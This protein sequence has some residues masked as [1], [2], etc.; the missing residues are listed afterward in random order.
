MTARAD[1]STR[2]DR[3]QG[4]GER[5][6]CARLRGSVLLLPLM[7]FRAN[8][9]SARRR[10]RPPCRRTRWSGNTGSPGARAQR[11]TADGQRHGRRAAEATRRC[12]GQIP[13]LSDGHRQLR[14]ST[15]ATLLLWTCGVLTHRLLGSTCLLG[16]GLFALRRGPSVLLLPTECVLPTHRELRRPLVLQLPMSRRGSVTRRRCCCRRRAALLAFAV[17]GSTACAA[18]V[19]PSSVPSDAQPAATMLGSAVDSDAV[20]ARSLDS[21]LD[22]GISTSDTGLGASAG[23]LVS[24]GGD[25]G[26]V[27][28]GT[29]DATG[30]DAVAVALDAGFDAVWP[31]ISARV[32]D[33]GLVPCSPYFPP[34]PAEPEVCN[35]SR[36]AA[37]VAR[38]WIRLHGRGASERELPRVRRLPHDAALLRHA[39]DLA[40]RARIHTASSASAPQVDCSRCSSVVCPTSLPYPIRCPQTG[41]FVDRRFLLPQCRAL[42]P[43]AQGRGPRSLLINAS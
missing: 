14:L 16:R 35:L 34:D 17:A 29:V 12:L 21:A 9:T 15:G 38:P 10:L 26:D 13:A 20:A 41:A 19:V 7:R 27:R 11:S 40:A 33:A 42:G 23:Q 32:C 5:R 6:E 22:A 31:E 37:F 39:T 28:T 36:E 1:T 4:T 24:P 3:A 43:R 18:R 25:R 2:F 8:P 30:L